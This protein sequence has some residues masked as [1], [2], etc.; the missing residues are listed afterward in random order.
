MG[1]VRTL[2]REG[3][4][5]E[6]VAIDVRGPRLRE[7]AQQRKEHGPTRQR[8]RVVTRTDAAST[9]V[10][11][12][13]TR[14]EQ[15]FD[16]GQIRYRY[17]LEK[18]P[19]GAT[20]S[21]HLRALTWAGARGRYGGEVPAAVGRQLTAELAL[22]EEL[23]YGGYFLT[24]YEIVQFCRRSNILCQGRGSAANSAV[25]FCLG[26][27]A[28]DPVRRINAVFPAD[29]WARA[30]AAAADAR[31][32]AAR[33]RAR[34]PPARRRRLRWRSVSACPGGCQIP[35]CPTAR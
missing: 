5:D 9:G 30:R 15:R 3:A 13:S 4:E 10:D 11:D 19:S 14:C 34:I 16:L 2:R 18:L 7:R 26:I 27:T 29:R 21:E 22:I 1:I 20:T 24:M 28:V 25:C 23:D 35:P 32:E 17:P 12:E 6:R 31:T 33:P 8:S